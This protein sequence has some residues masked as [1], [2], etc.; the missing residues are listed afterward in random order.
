MTA[1]RQN[2]F[3]LML[4]DREIEAIQTYRFA[5]RVGTKAEAVRG[6]IKLGLALQKAKGAAEGATSP[7]LDNQPTL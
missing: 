5:N 2:R 4:S 1:L 7:R 3:V 6:L